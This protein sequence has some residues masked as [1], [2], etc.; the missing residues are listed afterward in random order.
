MDQRSQ[1]HR[2][3]ANAAD[4]SSRNTCLGHTAL[5]TGRR[6]A[7]RTDHKLLFTAAL[8]A[9][10]SGLTLTHNYLSGYL[11]TSQADLDLT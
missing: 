7:C 1:H 3:T 9:G 5:A 2:F 10:A 4:I 11:A 6:A 8:K